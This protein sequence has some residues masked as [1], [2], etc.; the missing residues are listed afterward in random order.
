MSKVKVLASALVANCG[1]RVLVLPNSAVVVVRLRGLGRPLRDDLSGLHQ[2]LFAPPQTPWY[3]PRDEG[4]VGA[5]LTS[6]WRRWLRAAGI[7]TPSLRWA[8]RV[9]HTIT[10]HDVVIEVYRVD[11]DGPGAAALDETVEPGR[12]WSTLRESLADAGD[13]PLTTPAKRCLGLRPDSCKTRQR[14]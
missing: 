14:S 5:L 13:P 1:D 6:A 7:P 11:V 4:D 9:R 2:G 12:R 3:A 10:H 8:G